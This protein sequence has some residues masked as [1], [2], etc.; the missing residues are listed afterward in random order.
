MRKTALFISFK[1]PFIPYILSKN[2]EHLKLK[3]VAYTYIFKNNNGTTKIK[4]KTTRHI[5]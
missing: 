4:K 3:A 1:Y 5:K 2:D